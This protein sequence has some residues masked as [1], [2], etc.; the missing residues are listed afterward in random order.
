MILRRSCFAHCFTNHGTY[1]SI[2]F[3]FYQPTNDFRIVRILYFGNVYNPIYVEKQPPKVEVYSLARN[4]WRR[5]GTNAGYM[6]MTNC[7][8]HFSMKHSIGMLLK[9]EKQPQAMLFCCLILI[10][11]SLQR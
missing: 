5:I 7:L 1:F 10:L 2:G 3:G 4:S 9:L 11:R 8:Q 6:Q